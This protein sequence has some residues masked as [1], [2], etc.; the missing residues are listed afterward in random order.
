MVQRQTLLVGSMPFENEEAAMQRALNALGS[1]LIS[2]PDGEIGEKTAEFPNG[3]R[4][5]WVMTAINICS[6]DTENW[7]V[8]KAPVNDANG[9]PKDYS[10]VQRLKPRRPPSEMHKYLKFGYDDY[11][12]HSYPIFQKLRQEKGLPDLKFQVGIPTGLGISFS[13]MN[14]IDALRYSDAFNKRLAYEVNEI[15]KIAGDDVVIQIEVPGELAMAYQLPGLLVGLSLRSI[16]G[17]VNKIEPKAQFGVHICLGDLN[18]IA[19]VHAKTLKKMVHFSNSLV[20]GWPKTHKLAYVHYPLAEA[21]TPP[22]LD[23]DFYQPLRDIRLPQGTSFIA[24]LIHEKRSE[25]DQRQ[26]LKIIED[27]RGQTVGVACSCG[28]GRRPAAIAQYLI[29]TMAKV[30]QSGDWQAQDDPSGSPQ[31]VVEVGQANQTTA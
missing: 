26:L 9:F 7:Q 29:E 16:Y 21:A 4:S 27:V 10:G 8:V 5:A 6:R 2:L 30:S 15:L 31:H 18:N 11:F 3:S 25:Q 1:S 20:S 14:P 12:K 13:M 23:K 17:L 22:T 28:L 19:L 24:G